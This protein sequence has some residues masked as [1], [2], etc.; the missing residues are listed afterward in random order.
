MRIP[1]VG[2]PWTPGPGPRPRRCATE[3]LGD[4]IE[5]LRKKRHVPGVNAQGVLRR[6]GDPPGGL[7]FGR[8]G[9]RFGDPWG[10]VRNRAGLATDGWGCG[11]R[12]S[13]SRN[14]RGGTWFREGRYLG[15]EARR[16]ARDVRVPGFAGVGCRC[17]RVGMRFVEGRSEERTRR[18]GVRTRAR[19]RRTLRSVPAGPSWVDPSPLD[20]PRKATAELGDCT[21]VVADVARVHR[22]CGGVLFLRVYQ[23]AAQM[24]GHALTTWKGAG[25]CPVPVGASVHSAASASASSDENASTS[26]GLSASSSSSESSMSSARRVSP[27]SGRRVDALRGTL[28]RRVPGRGVARSSSSRR[29]GRTW[30]A[31]RRSLRAACLA[32]ANELSQRFVDGLAGGED[33]RHV[34]VEQYDVRL[35]AVMRGRP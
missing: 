27:T 8:V 30:E 12:P 31:A 21:R 1:G 29:P 33:L 24:R 2:N 22:G 7:A 32:E 5:H 16:G 10:A 14:G 26:I 19:S 18:S 11:S 23:R 15:P 4:G 25:G 28:A 13:G 20:L 34:A 35:L 9:A 17:E 6:D 3:S